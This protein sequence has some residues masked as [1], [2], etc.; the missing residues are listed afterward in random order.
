MT[1]REEFQE[2]L[3]QAAAKAKLFKHPEIEEKP[4]VIKPWGIELIVAREY[5]DEY[6]ITFKRMFINKGECLSLQI[7]KEKS[8]NM[9]VV[10]GMGKF[11]IEDKVF[12]VKP[13]DE[14][15]VLREER[16][17]IEAITNMEVWE[18]SIGFDDDIVR[19]E[20]KYARK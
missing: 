8:E 3:K 19:L 2:R 14:M 13:G 1:D 17:R 5:T 12:E 15:V 16:H 7:H 6:P 10:K 11:T 18:M 20:D 9:I 4:F